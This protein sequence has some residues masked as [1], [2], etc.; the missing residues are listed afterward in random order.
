[1]VIESDKGY[2]PAQRRFEI[3][4]DEFSSE[5][6]GKLQE[7][8]REISAKFPEVHIAFSLFGSLS[9]GKTLRYGALGYQGYRHQASETDIDVVVLYDVQEVARVHQELLRKYP[10]YRSRY[11]VLVADESLDPH[12]AAF[13]FGRLLSDEVHATVE[14]LLDNQIKLHLHMQEAALTGERSPLNYAVA[15]MNSFS[16]FLGDKGHIP[17]PTV[18]GRRLRTQ[19]TN[20]L[21]L[22]IHNLSS[23]FHRDIGGGLV[24]YQQRFMQDLA[25]LDEPT[26]ERLWQYANKSTR[27]FERGGK[28][29][30]KAEKDF[31]STYEAAV[32]FYGLPPKK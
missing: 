15:F 24:R 11:K 8:Y 4:D 32:R 29:P 3:S 19:W 27:L 6:I 23:F 22:H 12:K 26:R 14:K 7:A 5:R 18:E 31:P 30:Q 28:I 16:G 2:P 25:A 9:K 20:D 1:M 10:S 21:S 17:P 13:E